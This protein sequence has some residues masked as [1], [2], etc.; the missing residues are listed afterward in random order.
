MEP[1]EKSLGKMVLA[2]PD[3]PASPYEEAIFSAMHGYIP[4]FEA[5]MAAII[6]SGGLSTEASS[7]GLGLALTQLLGS[8]LIQHCS[9]MAL[10]K[11]QVLETE[12]ATI[13]ENIR[14]LVEEHYDERL[15]D[16]LQRAAEKE[17]KQ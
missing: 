15:A 12:L 10:S 1:A 2:D 4:V 5:V 9:A 11:E 13:T 3:A 14:R 17:S 16:V 6:N 7:R 8:H